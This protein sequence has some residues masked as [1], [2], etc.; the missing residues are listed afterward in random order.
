MDD[1]LRTH[2]KNL[3]STDRQEQYEA[4]MA[5]LAASDQP[6]DWAYQAWDELL[7]NLRHKDNHNRAIAAQILA[8]LAK[9]D[10]QMRMLDDFEALLVVTLDERFVTARHCLQS[11][12]KVG[13]AGKAQQTIFLAGMERRYRECVTEK[14]TTLTRYDILQGLRNL[15][16]QVGDESIKTKALAW[17]ELENDSKYRK[18]FARL[19][20]G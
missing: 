16:Q 8:N 4:F 15:Y 11:L 10:P 9:S 14:N 12:W 13:A 2:L 6:V 3:W 5:V 19:W 1:T 7:A 20:R 18:K 17:I